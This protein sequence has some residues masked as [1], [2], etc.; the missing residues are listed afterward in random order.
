MSETISTV[1]TLIDRVRQ[2]KLGFTYYFVDREMP[3]FSLKE[4]STKVGAMPTSIFGVEPSAIVSKIFAIL[5]KSN[6]IYS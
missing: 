1:S 3:R 4:T 5:S 6:S 2:L